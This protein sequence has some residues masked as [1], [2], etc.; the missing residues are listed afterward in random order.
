[1]LTKIRERAADALLR[2]ELLCGEANFRTLMKLSR[3]RY[4]LVRESSCTR[5]S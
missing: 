2:P 1:M 3:V 4:S 5:N